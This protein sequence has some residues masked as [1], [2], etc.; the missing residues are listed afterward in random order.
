MRSTFRRS[1]NE[2]RAQAQRLQ[3]A[4]EASL[5]KRYYVVPDFTVA[6]AA[7]RQGVGLVADDDFAQVG[8]ALQVRGFVSAEVRRH[9]GDAAVGFDAG[10]C[11]G[12]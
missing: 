7:R 10:N 5:L 8:R 6:E 9:G 11:V 12:G 3:G 4:L 1:V 2:V